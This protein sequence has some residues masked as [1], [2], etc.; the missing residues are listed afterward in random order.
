MNQGLFLIHSM[1]WRMFSFS[2]QTGSVSVPMARR[3]S[4]V[5]MYDG[6]MTGVMDSGVHGTAAAVAHHHDQFY[7]QMAAAYSMLPSSKSPMTFPATRMVK[8]SPMPP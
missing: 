4:S 1:L 3:I 8:I 2:Q 6:I 5:D 7:A